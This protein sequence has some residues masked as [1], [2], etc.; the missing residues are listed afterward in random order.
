MIAE[1]RILST[2]NKRSLIY[3]NDLKE[4]VAAAHRHDMPDDSEVQVEK[5]DNG[6]WRL[7]ITKKVD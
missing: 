2:H 4:M 5:D 3:L 6:Y 7:I 1:I